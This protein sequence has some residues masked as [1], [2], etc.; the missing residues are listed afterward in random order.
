MAH[1]YYR[2]QVKY[3]KH[4]SVPQTLINDLSKRA[5]QKLKMMIFIK[6]HYSTVNGLA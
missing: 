5:E 2:G 4:L 6:M 1:I 3:Q